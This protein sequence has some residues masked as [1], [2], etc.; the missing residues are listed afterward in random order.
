MI[1]GGYAVLAYGPPRYSNEVDVVIPKK[2]ALPVRAWLETEGLRLAKRSV[3]NPQNFDGQV[4]RYRSD[5]ITVDLL[6]DA[7]RD[8]DAQV[9]I[10]E[11]WVSKGARRVKLVTLSGR[12]SVEVPIARP[13]ALWALKLQ[14]GRPRD[15]SD[16]FAIAATPF[17][18]AEVEA[19]FQRL[20]TKSLVDKLRSVRSQ[21]RTPKTYAD[22]LSRR[23]L[24]KPTDPA[25]IRRWDRFVST[26]DRIMRPLGAGEQT[27]SA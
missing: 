11:R 15:I 7:V 3:P 5:S 16:L 6:A 1:I 12:T 14:A 24:G 8:R 10:P 9:D 17:D 20:K 13:E 22:S 26:I 19:L 23:Q 27:R 21:V 25:N 18:A 2:V 4:E